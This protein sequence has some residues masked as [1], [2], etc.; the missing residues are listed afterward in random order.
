MTNQVKVNSV[1]E[2]FVFPPKRDDEEVKRLVYNAIF[3]FRGDGHD[4]ITAIG[5]LYVGRLF[6]WR[7]IRLIFSS[8]R[9]AEF[10][11]ILTMGMQDN[12]PFK[13][14]DWMRDDERLTYRSFGL[15]LVDKAQAFWDTVRGVNSVPLSDK[16]LFDE[17]AIDKPT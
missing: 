5:C 1:E 6:G 3:N 7:V 12:Q 17:S 13:F 11:R 14:A 8:R 15:E 16:R 2:L 9:Y 10:Q 4:L